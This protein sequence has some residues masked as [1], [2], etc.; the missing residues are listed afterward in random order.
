MEEFYR[1]SLW[2]ELSM[3]EEHQTMKYVNGL[4]YTIQELVALH[5]VFFVDETHNKVM[6]IERL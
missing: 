1:L 4:R 6:K 2:Y 3:T 5:D